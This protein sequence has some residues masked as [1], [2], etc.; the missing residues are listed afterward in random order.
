LVKRAA[1]YCE[2]TPSQTGLRIIGH[3]SG[4]R[5]LRKQPVPEA[6]GV[7]LESYRACEKYITVTGHH[8]EGT[9]QTLNDISELIDCVVAELD[10]DKDK[11]DKEDNDDTDDTDDERE[12]STPLPQSLR[13]R[14]YIKNDGANKRHADYASR[15]ELTFVF[16]IEALRSRVSA[17]HIIAACLDNNSLA[18]PFTSTVEIMAVVSTLDVRSSRRLPKSKTNSTLWWGKSIK[19]TPWSWP[20]I[21]PRL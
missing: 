11:G 19:H 4:A 2:V 6:N 20:E 16:I 21:R 3:A 10:A 1:S 7:T 17:K 18:V 9:P 15:S 5:L 8:V 14:L 12:H 13:T